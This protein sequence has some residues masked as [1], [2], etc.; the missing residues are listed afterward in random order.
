MQRLLTI[1]FLTLA[2]FTFNAETAHA[3][4]QTF[5]G[6]VGNAFGPDKPGFVVLFMVLMAIIGWTGGYIASILGQVQI[7]QMIRIGAAFTCIISVGSL[8]W[9]AIRTLFMF[10]GIK[11]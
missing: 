4:Q 5:W 11:I 1:V 8:A 2:Y 7:A 6:V 3:A 10:A 9:Q